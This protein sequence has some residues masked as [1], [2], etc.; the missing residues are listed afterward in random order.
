MEL[1]TYR[2]PIEFRDCVFPFLNRNEA[3]NCLGIGVVNTLISSPET[4]PKS[5]LWAF[6]D[7]G[8]VVGAA[9]MTP[10]QPIG[11]TEM[12]SKAIELLIQELSNL[13]DRP[14]GVVGPK[15]QTDCFKDRWTKA[16]K[17]TI[18]F[19]MEQR[20]YQIV[21][22]KMPFHV[23]GEMRVA[24]RHDLELIEAWSLKFMIDCGLGNDLQTAKE[25]ASRAIRNK[26]RYLWILNGE[27]V[28]M[29]GVSGP[30]PSGIRVSWVYTPDHLR[31]K[32]Y[33]SAVVAAL[34]Q[35]M[36]S[37]GHKFCFLYTD[38]A[39]S[40]SNSIYQKIGYQAVCDSVHHTF[41]AGHR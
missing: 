19:T 34:S 31:G 11:L 28:A 26:G 37:E 40:T 4:Y 2:D 25:S 41:G 36:L 29:A 6:T 21:D 12:P 5:Y 8:Q 30:T 33:A 24:K 16:H 22:V 13:P 18:P 27:A 32:G 17:L 35:R 39:N 3:Q 7:A 1:R 20:I 14:N 38:L 15:S 9:W 10:P 23:S